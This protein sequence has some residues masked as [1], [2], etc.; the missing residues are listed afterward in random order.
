MNDLHAD[1]TELRAFMSAVFRYATQDTYIALRGFGEGARNVPAFLVR[2]LKVNGSLEAMLTQVA[3][4]AE[5]CAQADAAAVF[6][7]P[8]CTFSNP[9]YAKGSDVA[10]GLT[11]SV[12]IDNGDPDKARQRLEGMLGAATV[13]VRSGSDW[14]DPDTGEIKPKMH[15]HWRLSE[16]ATTHAEHETLRQARVIAATLVGADPTGAPVSHPFRWPGSW[17]RKAKPRLTTATYNNDA[18]INLSEA[19]DA[20]EGAMEAEGRAKA[21]MPFS[22][23]PEAPLR[24]VASAMA[25]IPNPASDVPYDQWVRLGYAIHRATGGGRDGFALWDEWSAKSDKYNATETAAVWRRIANATAGKPPPRTIGAGTIFYLAGAAGWVRPFPFSGSDIG[26]P[27]P[28]ADQDWFA[29]QGQPDNRTDKPDNRTKPRPAILSLP[30]LDALPPPEWL[31]EG[32]IPEAS[33]T[34]AY[35]PPKAGK[36]FIILSMAL[37]VAAGL[38]WWGKKVR[39]GAVVYIAGEGVGGLSMRIRAMREYHKIPINIPFWV[40]PRAVNFRSEDDVRALAK[41][42]RETVAN[43]P[44]KLAI[45]DTLARAMPG[46]DENSAQETGLVIHAMEWLKEELNATCLPIHH[47]GKDAERGARGTSALRGAWDAAL[48]IT[49]SGKVVTLTVADQKDAEAGEVMRFDMVEQL[50]T[51]SRS[52]LVP[53]LNADPAPG[54]EQE[55]R[56]PDGASGILYR[57]ILDLMS[58]AESAV[59]SP[60]SDIPPDVRGVDLE[61]VQQTFNARSPAKTPGAKKKAFTRSLTKLEKLRLIGVNSP[62][63]WVV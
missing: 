58:G 3:A 7:P 24:D 30:E 2:P 36:T 60:Q 28:D 29:R 26:Q 13:V 37:H 6:A 55:D 40:I 38:D 53:V 22:G 50:V 14:T 49:A 8:V 20:L 1:E 31:I 27:P 63:V 56:A 62:W 47:Q 45:V 25:A 17:H 12:E 11:L 41:L 4:A 48:Q 21:E 39:Q 61:R 44:V 23:T 57:S 5:D 52:S 42:I 35:G 32:L 46:A 10:D 59:G 54:T 43:V 19:M 16:P 15:L 51:A 9:Y 33:L 18:E 34:F